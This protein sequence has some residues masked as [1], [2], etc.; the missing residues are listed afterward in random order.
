M[1]TSD[2]PITDPELRAEIER[3]GVIK[4]FEPDMVLL[5][6]GNHIKMV[7][8]VLSGCLKICRE[9]DEGRDMLLYYIRPGESCIMSFLGGLHQ[10]DSKVKAIVDEPSQVLFLPVDKVNQWV[11]NYQ[12]WNEFMF[13]LYHKRFE[14]LLNLVNAIAFQKVDSRLIDL[15]QQKI[16]RLG[17]NELSVTHQQLADELNTARE[18]V[19]R[20]LKQLEKDGKVEL[21][22]NK[23]RIISLV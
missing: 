18:V 11:K 13:R 23:I 14:E 16:E 7:P 5:R 20:L 9:D 6:E 17:S 4:D 22:R 12:S 19:S 1:Q 8:V 3:W 2:L 21:S 15:L 10:S